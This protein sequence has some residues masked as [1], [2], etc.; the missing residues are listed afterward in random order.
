[1]GR[2]SHKNFVVLE[3]RF[4][5]KHSLLLGLL[6]QWENITLIDLLTKL[7]PV[8]EDSF[9]VIKL[10]ES[11]DFNILGSELAALGD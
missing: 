3:Q 1:M 7:W 8:Y 4:G 11:R 9:T 2:I 5:L 6:Q 10:N